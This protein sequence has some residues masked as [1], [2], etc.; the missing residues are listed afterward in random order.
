MGSQ[1]RV[2]GNGCVEDFGVTGWLVRD[3]GGLGTGGAAGSKE[4]IAEGRKGK[5]NTG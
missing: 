2:T 1:V 3:V 4:E 5:T